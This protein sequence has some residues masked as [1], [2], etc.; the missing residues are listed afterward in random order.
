MSAFDDIRDAGTS[1]GKV[2]YGLGALLLFTLLALLAISG[3]IVYRS[4]NPPR[5]EP[6]DI[7][8]LMGNPEAVPF[9]AAGKKLEGW[10]FPGLR[11]APTIILCHGYQSNRLELLTMAAALQEHQFNVFVFDLAGHGASTGFTSLGPRENKQLIAA[12]NELAR[13]DDVD[14]ERFGVWGANLGGYAAVSAAAAD[15]RIRAFAVESV[16]DRPQDMLGL[17]VGR[18][19]L[20]SLPLVDRLAQWEFAILNF[21]SRNAKPL[22]ELLPQ[23][24]NTAKL[25]IQARDAAELADSTMQLFLKSPEP[26]QQAI[27]QKSNYGSLLEDERREYDSKVVNFFLQSMPALPVR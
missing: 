3:S 9:Q 25:F 5:T 18:A 8:T 2:T 21:S 4:L 19:G 24:K 16:Y 20:S 10:L 6:V 23:M 13:R 27:I 14:R 15:P 22:S 26:K 12:I 1:L 11:G 17:L 7:A